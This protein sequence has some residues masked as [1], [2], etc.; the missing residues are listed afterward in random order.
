[1]AVYEIKLPKPQTNRKAQMTVQRV[2]GGKREVEKKLQLQDAAT[3]VLTSVLCNGHTVELKI[4]D[5]RHSS[6][7]GRNRESGN[8]RNATKV[9][10]IPRTI[11]VAG[12][13]EPVLNN[14][15]VLMDVCVNH[16]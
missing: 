12:Y 15:I 9:I 2:S 16:N 4:F 5:G 3:L 11:S 7:A 1:M 6:I 8:S 10:F 14:N 13:N